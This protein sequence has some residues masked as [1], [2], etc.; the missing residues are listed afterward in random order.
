MASWEEWQTVYERFPVD[1]PAT[2]PRWRV[3]RPDVRLERVKRALATPFVKRKCLLL[4]T[5]GSGKTTEL[6]ALLGE[7]PGNRVGVYFDVAQHVRDKLGDERVMDRMAAWEVVFLAG[8]AVWRA[9]RQLGFVAEEEGAAIASAAAPLL[10]VPGQ[11]APVVDYAK[12]AGAMVVGLATAAGAAAALPGFA[13]TASAVGALQ[14]LGQVAGAGEWKLPFGKRGPAPPDADQ[15]ARRLLDAVNTLFRRVE[16]QQWR[17]VVVIDGL[18][19]VR[20]GGAIQ[21]LFLE[22]TLL[23]QL[24]T[25]TVATGPVALSRQARLGQ[26]AGWEPT[27]LPELTVFSADDA[28]VPAGQL[29]FF[30]EL[31]VRRTAD[32]SVTLDREGLE[33]LAWASGGRV[34]EFVR[35]VQNIAADA[36]GRQTAVA[37]LPLVDELV[38]Y[39]RQTFST[40]FHRGY[41]DVLCRVRDD[42][43]H[44][45]PDVEPRADGSNLVDELLARY[46]L[47]PYRNGKEWFYPHPL[48]LNRLSPRP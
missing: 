31:W 9:A 39:E 15:H 22:T 12:L 3:P 37:T 45:L 6:Q 5:Q 38:E 10:A 36:Y 11:P 19:R 44:Q 32:L 18:D 41:D 8:L 29:E 40:G 21:R 2:E 42:P 33:R 24:D 46:W 25:F 47:L 13:A 1:Q 17:F 34:R 27:V 30:A 4:G 16:S 28:A 7:L 14:F 23:G 35:L 26:L 43:E 20:D 48:L